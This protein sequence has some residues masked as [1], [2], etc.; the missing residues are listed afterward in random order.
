MTHENNSMRKER[1]YLESLYETWM[2][3][4]WNTICPPG[5]PIAI[6]PRSGEAPAFRARTLGTARLVERD[7][8]QRAIV[9]VTATPRPRPCPLRR[10]DVLTEEQFAASP[11]PSF[12]SGRIDARVEA[13]THAAAQ[14]I[15]M[16]EH[17]A[18]WRE[19]QVP[20]DQGAARALARTQGKAAG[21]GFRALE[22]A[23]DLGL[24]HGSPR[25]WIASFG[26]EVVQI[27]L[28]DYPLPQGVHR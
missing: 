10:L 9:V 7:R 3:R 19:R 1:R 14:A 15:E 11:L 13:A 20:G 21:L 23:Y 12:F 16:T 17:V 5:T 26:D 6:R 28:G 25:C 22:L 24:L 18:F 2:A 27:E 4:Q 8:A